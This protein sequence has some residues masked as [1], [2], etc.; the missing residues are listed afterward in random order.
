MGG[1]LQPYITIDEGYYNA[2]ELA[3]ALQTVLNNDIPAGGTWTVS[4]SDITNKFTFSHTVVT[5]T[6]DYTGNTIMDILGFS[7]TTSPASSSVKSTN[8]FLLTG[9]NQCI[10]MVGD[11]TDNFSNTNQEGDITG[12]RDYFGSIALTSLPGSFTFFEINS[13]YPMCYYFRKGKKR[14]LDKLRIQFFLRFL[15]DMY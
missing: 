9:E 11:E 3:T 14:S 8:Q 13:D 4:S 7:E 2:T 10:L 6:L 15:L 12:Q 5:F 1:V